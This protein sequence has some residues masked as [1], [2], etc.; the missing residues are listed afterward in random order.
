MS[1]RLVRWSIAAALGVLVA[2]AVVAGVG[3]R[4]STLRKLVVQ[5]L[6]ERLDS[7]VELGAFSVDTFPT[8]HITGPHSSS[9]TGTGATCPRWSASIALRS[10]VGCSACRPGRAGSERHGH[11]T[12][13]Q[14]SAGRH[15]RRSQ[16]GQQDAAPRTDEAAIST[17]KTTMTMVRRDRRRPA[18]RRKRIAR[19]DSATGRQGAED[20]RREAADDGAAWKGK[21]MAY[22][23]P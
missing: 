2:M 17:K 4:T 16:R 3:S 9:A 14:H 10:T 20:L 5:T 6:S 1:I 22:Q 7:E 18:R 8:V 15:Q 13:H 21:V 19:A 11:R 12:A 23:A